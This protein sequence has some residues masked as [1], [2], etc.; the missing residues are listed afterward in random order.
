MRCRRSRSTH[1]VRWR[2]TRACE[3]ELRMLAAASER[4]RT[5]C[6]A[7][8]AASAVGDRHRRVDVVRTRRRARSARRRRYASSS[9]SSSSAPTPAPTGWVTSRTVVPCCCSRYEPVG[10][11]CVEETS[12]DAPDAMRNNPPCRLSL[13][14][15]TSVMSVESLKTWSTVGPFCCPL[16]TEEKYVQMFSSLLSIST[17]WRLDTWQMQN[18]GIGRRNCRGWGLGRDGTFLPKK[19]LRPRIRDYAS[20]PVPV[21]ALPDAGTHCAYS[22]PTERW[23]GWV[24]SGA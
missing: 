22:V 18:N 16:W 13:S 14:W 23:P 4:W 12:V 9:C 2:T 11:A 21:Y 24:H 19:T 20:R 8:A 17:D 1:V 7:S 5:V 3:V 10:A 15:N 6:G